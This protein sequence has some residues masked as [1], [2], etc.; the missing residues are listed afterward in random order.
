[1]PYHTVVVPCRLW[2]WFPEHTRVQDERLDA[3]ENSIPKY[4]VWSAG[5]GEKACVARLNPSA[6]PRSK[7][8]TINHRRVLAVGKPIGAIEE[9]ILTTA[10]LLRLTSAGREEN[11]KKTHDHI[12]TTCLLSVVM[13]QT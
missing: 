2:S 1:M 3:S 13:Q 4:G 6:T 10:T 8:Q 7:R 12:P 9:P 11:N 5:L